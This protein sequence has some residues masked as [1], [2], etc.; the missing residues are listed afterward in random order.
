MAV[1]RTGRHHERLSQVSSA[2]GTFVYDGSHVAVEHSPTAMRVGKDVP[3]LD[4]DGMPVV[5]KGVQ[6][7]QPAGQFVRGSDGNPVLGGKPKETRIKLTTKTVFGVEFPEG[8]PVVVTDRALAQKLRCLSGFSEVEA[9][10]EA[11]V[12]SE[13]EEKRKPG[14]PKKAE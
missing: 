14:R 6:Q 9:A 4:A 5:I 7:F 10:G 8:K 1:I 3:I 11:E 2:P 13:G 12:S